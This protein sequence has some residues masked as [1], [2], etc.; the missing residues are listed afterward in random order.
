MATDVVDKDGDRDGS[1]GQKRRRWWIKTKTLWTEIYTMC[2][3]GEVLIRDI[4]IFSFR[5]QCYFW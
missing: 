3:H 4:N 5:E 2:S 1:H